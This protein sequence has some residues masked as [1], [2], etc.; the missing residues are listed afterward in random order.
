M[1]N[2]LKFINLHTG[3]IYNGDMPYIHWFEG[4]QST[5]LFYTLKL[6]FITDND[7]MV[8]DEWRINVSIEDNSIFKLIDTSKIGNSLVAYDINELTS[9]NNIE[10]VGEE[11]NG[12]GRVYILYVLGHATV[13]GEYITPIH[14]GSDIYKVGADFY[15][16]N[17]SLYINLVNK[18]CEIPREIQK[19]LYPSNVHEDYND[20]ILLNRKWKELLSNY[21]D[22]LDNRGSYK[23]LINS[24]KWFEYGDNMKLYEVWRHYEGKNIWNGVKEIQEVM[25]DK[26]TMSR[27]SF[28]KTTFI[29]LGIALKQFVKDENGAVEWDED[30]NP[31]LEYITYKWSRE[32]MALKLGLLNKFYQTFFMPIH[33]DLLY[34][35]IEDVVY[36]KTIKHLTGT[37]WQRKDVQLY[38]NDVKSSVK[39][40]DKFYLGDVHCQVGPDTVFG[41]QWNGQTDYEDVNIVGVD[42]VVSKISTDV[43]AKTFYSQLYNGTG[44]MV[45]F[46][47]L[48]PIPLEDKIV[49]STI[50]FKN[51]P[52]GEYVKCVDNHTYNTRTIDNEI[53]LSFNLLCKYEMEYDVRMQF[54]TLMGYVFVKHI[55]FNCIDVDG[56]VM[57]VYKMT[58]KVLS[59]RTNPFDSHNDWMFSRQHNTTPYMQYIPL[60]KNQLNHLLTIRGDVKDQMYQRGYVTGEFTKGGESYTWAV[61]QE[62]GETELSENLGNLQE[63]VV[64][65]DYVFCPGFYN[66]N[67]L[68]GTK[69]YE[70]SNLSFEDFTVYANDVIFVKP[71]NRYSQLLDG[72]EWEF[73]NM[74]N[75]GRKTLI[76]NSTVEPY[77]ASNEK[78]LLTPGFYDIVF[79][80][81]VGK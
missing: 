22:I 78:E 68:G 15:G 5:D 55:R 36:A 49:K 59:E 20:N 75:T 9:S 61:R 8:E 57:E 17:E 67:I 26:Y 2:M 32:D 41:T 64:R 27:S 53:E 18:G 74:S 3:N 38:V 44:C 33:L 73:I 77:I 51:N 71:Q 43:E 19:A 47:L 66:S 16:E 58:P 60:T 50:Y 62:F 70:N 1:S 69:S 21:W 7:Y 54:E 63:Y 31:V 39:N 76:L 65:N 34:S 4:E 14:I 11:Y 12:I 80:Y 13:E 45:P 6:C 30:G 25:S 29:S 24:L 40:G 79:R 35:T 72:N 28:M 52:E 23:S 42:A 10:L 81:K 37:S 46:K 48:F 56:I